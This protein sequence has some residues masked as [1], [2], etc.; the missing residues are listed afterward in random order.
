MTETEKMVNEFTNGLGG[1]RNQKIFNILEKNNLRAL[2]KSN[3][4]TLLFQYLGESGSKH[5]VFAFRLNPPIIS[6][7][8]S[9]W[10]ERKVE[11]KEH[12]EKFKYSE[13]PELAGPVSTSQYSSGQIEITRNTYERVVDICNF[14]CNRL[15]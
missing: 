15:K 13:K 3:T 1:S 14:V 10:L 5:D 12:L 8:Q 4:G 6:F 2:G 7:P 9:Y 11:L